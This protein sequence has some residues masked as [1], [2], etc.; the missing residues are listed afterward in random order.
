MKAFDYVITD[1]MG[2]HA[3]PAGLLKHK[4]EGYQS[5][6]VLS[7]GKKTAEASNPIAVLGLDVQK[8][9]TAHVVISGTDEEPACREMLAFFQENL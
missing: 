3:R 1:Q 8:G 9:Q 4:A 6:I 7:A 5:R 2:I